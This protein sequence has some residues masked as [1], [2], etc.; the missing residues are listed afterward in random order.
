MKLRIFFFIFL[1]IKTFISVSQISFQKTLGNNGNFHGT[2]IET[3]NDSA[4]IIAGYKEGT[5]TTGA[6]A[7]LV[8]INSLGDTIWTGKYNGSCSLPGNKAFSVKQTNSGEY[9]FTGVSCK[10]Q[11]SN[12]Y[13][14]TI[15]SIG[16]L[17]NWGE[18]FGG[19]GVGNE[20]IVKRNGAIAVAGAAEEFD[21]SGIN[22]ISR[23][24][25]LNYVSM[26][27]PFQITVG[28]TL[29]FT[30]AKS[31]KETKDNGIILL[32]NDGYLFQIDS[33]NTVVWSN[34]YFGCF[35]GNFLNKT[36][37]GGY[38]VTGSTIDTAGRNVYLLKVDS[39]GNI[40]WEKS[41]GGL[42]DDY[43]FYTQETRDSGF[44]IVGKTFSF[45]NGS[46]DVYLIKTD[47]LG[48]LLWSKTF[49]GLG[50][51]EGI[52]LKQTNDGGYMIVG[53]IFYASQ[54]KLY[55]IKTDSSGNNLCNIN[56]PPTNENSLTSS[57]IS[58]T[59]HTGS[60]GTSIGG[61][62]NW[63]TF[64]K[65]LNVGVLCSNLNLTKVQD[66]TQIS[67]FPNPS[68]NNINLKIDAAYYKAL[69]VT[70][71]NTL[72]EDVFHLT[73]NSFVKDC[74]IKLNP[75][76]KDGIYFIRVYNDEL[77]YSQKLVISQN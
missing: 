73:N 4:F 49:G 25:L 11:T 14:T 74:V 48:N 58:K 43:G 8:K 24:A 54:N 35:E 30:S 29:G 61:N 2:C 64:T 17:L 65:S 6:Q 66:N 75:N 52:S 55:L 63:F 12:V 45:G 32:T 46:S 47:S 18:I 1:T 60:P 23:G 40:I 31:I 39:I 19:Y 70:I 71:N 41:F 76:L 16:Q 9:V 50:D 38:I 62:Q 15:D 72:G 28:D 44:V 57:K 21:S 77:N 42:Q 26:S 27:S 13:V 33:N 20:I 59:T 7:I 53:T 56:N 10:G 68:K 67:I 3:T 36:I 69:N 51:D 37:D 22:T 34:K 5:S